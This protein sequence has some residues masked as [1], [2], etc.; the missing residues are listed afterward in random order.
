MASTMPNMV[1][2]LIEK[3]STSITA[4]VSRYCTSL[5]ANDSRGGAG[6]D[7][8]FHA[9]TVYLRAGRGY[10]GDAAGARRTGVGN[11]FALQNLLKMTV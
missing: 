2:T 5:T 7:T 3:P 1:S 8:A 9:V 4:K 6:I 11:V 10:G